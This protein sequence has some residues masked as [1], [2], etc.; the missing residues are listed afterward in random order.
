ME[1]HSHGNGQ[2]PE[3]A[4]SCRKELITDC[5][6]KAASNQ[7]ECKLMTAGL[8]ESGHRRMAGASSLRG[9]Y[10]SGMPTYL[11]LA[12]RF[13]HRPTYEPHEIF[14]ASAAGQRLK[15]QQVL[16][17][18]YSVVIAPANYGKTTEMMEQVKRMR[19][20]GGGAV[21]V[22]LRKVADRASFAKAL[23]PAERSAFYAWRDAPTAPLT[24]FVDS[25][26]EASAAQR[27]G[28]ADLIA[29][30][31]TEV[32]WPNA[33]IR[34]VISTRPAVLS[35]SVRESITSQ[36]V[37]PYETTIRATTGKFAAAAAGSST[38]SA[39]GGICDTYKA[40]GSS[41]E[42]WRQGGEGR[43]CS[44]C[45]GQSGGYGHDRAREPA[46]VRRR[47]KG[48]PA[49]VMMRPLGLRNGWS[50]TWLAWN[51]VCMVEARVFES[52]FLV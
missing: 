8:L 28:I 38:T 39:G 34:W 44:C 7:S 45:Q 14:V 15:W 6:L 46:K 10:I 36:L 17:N 9:W 32:G 37:V 25:L 22:A 47:E 52:S 13:V 18:R 43:S 16:E 20:A 48:H 1:G 26:D 21:F 50:N 49:C 30:V 24:L 51:A 31:A 40:C 42:R 29:E 4:K 5:S 41:E 2:H 19:L 35:T 27:D 33:L 12:R 11:D 3:W 23:E